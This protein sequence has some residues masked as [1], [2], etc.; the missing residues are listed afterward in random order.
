MAW[1]VAIPIFWRTGWIYSIAALNTIS[2]WTLAK[3]EFTAWR[4]DVPT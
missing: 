2:L 4:A 1:I 3:T